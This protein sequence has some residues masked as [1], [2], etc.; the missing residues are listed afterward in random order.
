VR[1][2]GR[3]SWHIGTRKA[4]ARYERQFRG[5]GLFERLLFRLAWM[6]GHC[7]GGKIALEKI[8][9]ETPEE[10]RSARAYLEGVERIKANI[11]HD[12]ADIDKLDKQIKKI[13]ESKKS[14][15]AEMTKGAV[16]IPGSHISNIARWLLPDKVY[17]RY[18]YPR[19]SD[20]QCEYVDALAGGQRIRARCIVLLGHLSLIP[21][22]VYAHIAL[23]L[24][25]HFSGS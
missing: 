9:S 13:A 15:R 8:E 6:S 4:L 7:E 18:V 24:E 20:M 19:I 5:R 25:K 22:W 21:G 12:K 16:R 10:A 11:E 3:A 23:W 14:I 17:K 2:F 1:L